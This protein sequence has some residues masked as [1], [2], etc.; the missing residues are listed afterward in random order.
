MTQGILFMDVDGTMTDGFIN[1]CES[2]ELYKSFNV[3]DGYGISNLLPQIDYVPVVLT[4]RESSITIERCKELKIEECHQG[5]KNKKK[6]MTAI[7]DKFDLRLEN[8]AYIG[9]DLN[10]LECLEL[11]KFSGGLTGCPLDAVEEVKKV[12]SFVS[13]KEGGKGA[14]REFIEYIVAS[15]YLND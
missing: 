9:D 11:I 12:C 15:K 2:G 13:K 10:D 8:A 1:I 5:I 14:I 7:L 4:G 6:K 3:K